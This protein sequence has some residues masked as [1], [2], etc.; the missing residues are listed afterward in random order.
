[1]KKL[2]IIRHA[3]AVPRRAGLADLERPLVKK[4]TV[5]ARET[6]LRLKKAGFKP[7]LIVSS[8]ANRALET[9]QAAAR[10]Y[11]YPLQKIRLEDV[12]YEKTTNKA[13]LD[14]VHGLDRSSQTVFL[15]GHN[16][17]LLRF[18]Q[19]LAKDFQ[20]RLPKMGVFGL[21]FS[22][23]SWK[24]VAPGAARSVYFDFPGRESEDRRRSLE[25][26][27]RRLSRAAEAALKKVEADIPKEVE[28]RAGRYSRKLAA[29][30]L[31]ALK[32]REEKRSKKKQA[33][34]HQGSA[35]SG[36]RSKSPSKPRRGAPPAAELRP[37]AEPGQTETGSRRAPARPASGT[38]TSPVTPLPE[39]K[40]DVRSQPSS[41]E[42]LPGTPSPKDGKDGEGPQD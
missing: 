7:D 38:G 13:I 22:V 23:N 4:G 36:A 15:F 18:A 34:P 41:G 42:V 40:E 26:L 39:T 24:G 28:E 35:D 11:G 8:P 14:L 30:F 33:R 5:S 2:F 29:Q 27:S 9:A 32:E 1:M 12:L 37:K 31:D 17:A 6:A 25:D 19:F 3:K 20:V 21:E 10:E 16:P